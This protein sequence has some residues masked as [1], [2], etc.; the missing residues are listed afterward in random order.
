MKTRIIYLVLFAIIF[1]TYLIGQSSWTRITP[2]PQ[3]TTLK[4]ITKIPGT[5]NLITTGGGSTVMISSDAGETWQINHHPAGLDNNFVGECIYFLNSDIGFIGGANRTILKTVDGGNNWDT[6]YYSGGPNWQCFRDI[7]FCNETTGFAVG[8]YT[9]IKKTTDGG[10]TWINLEVG[11]DFNLHQV[12]FCSETIGFIIGSSNEYILKTIDGGNSWQ[13]INYPTGLENLSLEE[14]QFVNETTGFVYCDA[15]YPNYDGAICKTSDS[16]ITWVNVFDDPS[17]Y[18]GSID[19][20]D[21]QHGIIGAGDGMY[22]SKIL[23]TE[24]GGEDWTEIELPGFSWWSTNSVCFLDQDNAFSVGSMG[25]IFKS[26]DGGQVWEAKHHRDFYGNIYQLQFINES[27]GFALATNHTGGLASSDLMKTIDGGLNWVGCSG[28]WNYDGAFYFVN[29]YLG[30]LAF[31]DFGLQVRKT[32]NGGDEWSWTETGF[33]FE[34]QDIKFYGTNTGLIVGEYQIIKTTDSGITWEEVFY[35]PTFW[36]NFYD[37]EFISEEE[38]FIVGAD[39]NYSTTAVYKSND[40]GNSWVIDSIGNYWAARDLFFVDDNIAFIACEN[41]AI[42]KSVD[43]CDTWTETMIDS[44]NPISFRSIYFPSNNIGY[45]VGDGPLETIVKSTDGGETWEAIHSV[46]TSGLNG[47]YFSDENN[48]L[49]V[50]QGGVIL[51]TATGG[52]TGFEE[53][54]LISRNSIFDIYPNPFANYVTINLHQP[55]KFVTSQLILYDQTGKSIQNIPLINNS[56]NISLSFEHLKTGIYFLQLK[57]ANGIDEVKK[58]IK[59]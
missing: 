39:E 47:V 51:K 40:G 50:G 46:T 42:L 5:D 17:A 22:S 8:D 32:T 14:M 59:L 25:M 2:L 48:G 38:I 41:N 49:I 34:P 10:E 26:A 54:E 53:T 45:A 24:N 7:A 13:I 57:T 4:D 28:F 19:F 16:G 30:F 36:P 23:L 55:E 31:T 44:Q 12:E 29:E 6:V 21:D 15:G 18:S 9:S 1:P 43:G 35:S 58:M 52:I 11:N 20:I 3:E 56:D 27:T 33:D 37:I